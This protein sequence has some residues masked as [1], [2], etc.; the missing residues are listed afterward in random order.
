MKRKILFSCLLLISLTFASGQAAERY[1]I[2]VNLA[3]IRSG[4]GLS[5]PIVRR[6]Q[7]GTEIKVLKLEDDWYKI[8]LGNNKV[9]YI[10]N[11]LV[12]MEEIAEEAT[13]EP[14]EAAE[15]ATKETAEQL[16]E[17]AEE[18]TAETSTKTAEDLKAEAAAEEVIAKEM[19]TKEEVGKAEQKET[20]AKKEAKP[21]E[22]K[23]TEKKEA[24]LAK[25]SES[26][27]EAKEERAFLLE[28]ERETLWVS[29]IL[30]PGTAYVIG[31]AS[32]NFE[33]NNLSV[34]GKASAFFL[35]HLGVVASYSYA[36]I[37]PGVNSHSVAGGFR[38]KITPLSW[39]RIEPDATCGWY[40][41]DGSDDFGW[42][43]SLALLFGKELTSFSSYLGPFIKYETIYTANSAN[44]KLL[45]FGLA[46][47]LSNLAQTF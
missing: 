43:T 29:L 30:E 42:Q 35:S 22:K 13:E 1:L 5:K 31:D 37:R 9:G 12:A 24:K 27:K 3:N 7:K 25:K 11:D 34:T 6:Y 8:D 39:L 21:E 38:G 23:A 32:A 47:N 36:H 20:V 19:I 44:P 45:T 41:F 26:K 2:N 33:D 15:V 46:I 4:P 40:S 17:T 18:T 10:F 14:Q 28:D 16:P